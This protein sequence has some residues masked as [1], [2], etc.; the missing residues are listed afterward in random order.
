MMVDGTARWVWKRVKNC[1]HHMYRSWDVLL[2]KRKLQN[3][4]YCLT[5]FVEKASVRGREVRIYM[6]PN[7]MRMHQH[8]AAWVCGG[9]TGQREKV[10]GRRRF[11][12]YLWM[13]FECCTILNVLSIIRLRN[14]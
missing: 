4:E 8:R 2:Q 1:V 12:V 3:S 14:S 9:Q 13:L 5:L 7:S 6:W 10:A 11:A